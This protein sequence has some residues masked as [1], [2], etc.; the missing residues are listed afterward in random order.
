MPLS[1]PMPP[2][3]GRGLDKRWERF[4]PTPWLEYA[5]LTLL[6]AGVFVVRL[7]PQSVFDV[8]E[9]GTTAMMAAS[10]AAGAVG[11]PPP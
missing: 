8:V 3:S 4:A 5:A 11:G 6:V 1:V 2:P 9:Q 7:Y 10:G